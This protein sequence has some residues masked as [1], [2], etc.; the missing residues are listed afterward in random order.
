MTLS[1]KQERRPEKTP[2]DNT[3]QMKE[4]IDQFSE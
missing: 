3:E 2:A 4:K 1:Y